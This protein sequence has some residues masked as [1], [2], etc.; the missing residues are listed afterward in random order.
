MRSIVTGGAGFIGSHIA[1]AL[2]DAGHE[3]FVIDDLSKGKS[4]NIPEDVTFLKVSVTSPECE[5]L[6]ADIEPGAVFHLAAQ[7]DVRNSVADMVFDAHTNVEG[8]VR[9]A[10]AAAR[11]GTQS[12]IFASSGGAIY[13]EQQQFP[14]PETHP[15]K[16]ESPYGI[17]K[18][19]AEVY[20]DYF[21]RKTPMRA[22]MLR[23][24][25]VFG[26][27]QNPNGEAGVVSIFANQMLQGQTPTIFGDGLQTRD[28]VF[29]DDVMRA[30]LLALRHNAARGAY[31]IGTGLETNLN[32]LAQML[33]K[34][35]GFSGDV[36]HG[37]EK[38]GEQRRSVL[39]CARAKAELHWEPKVSMEEGLALTVE[40]LKKQ[41]PST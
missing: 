34:A 29:V 5:R 8:T 15:L 40:W 10:S 2:H 18:Q 23:F 21:A 35:T 3:V 39:S 25:N 36:R 9:V 27:R 7:M 1:Q 41:A 20:L 38:P 28:Y 4:Q 13:G 30:S 19:C 12:F 26:P 32:D 22:V 6:I 17:S 31:N 24:G 16:A 37:P 14:A 11:A 33:A